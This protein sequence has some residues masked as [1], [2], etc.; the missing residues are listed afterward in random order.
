MLINLLLFTILSLMR[1]AAHKETELVPPENPVM[2]EK[3]QVDYQEAAVG[4]AFASHSR[5]KKNSMETPL[6][7]T[8]TNEALFEILNLT[9]PSR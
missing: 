2:V 5:Q 6:S 3:M 1:G 9:G 8:S 7:F 4:I